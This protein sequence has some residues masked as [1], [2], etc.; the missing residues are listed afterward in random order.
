LQAG[1]SGKAFWV[2]EFG[3]NMA[4]GQAARLSRLSSVI[5]NV[6]NA[7]YANQPGCRGYG[8]WAAQPQGTLGLG[9]DW[10]MFD[11]TGAVRDALEPAF[12]ALPSVPRPALSD[13]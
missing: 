10:G 12:A 3:Q 4:A 11:A 7:T 6:F 5:N 13:Y 1:V 9:N 2:P 8:W